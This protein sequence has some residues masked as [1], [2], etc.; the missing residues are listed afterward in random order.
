MELIAFRG[1]Q[2]G[3]E[4]DGNTQVSD[5]G[6]QAVKSSLIGYVTGQNCVTGIRVGKLK[7][8]KPCRPFTVYIALYLDPIPVSHQ[9]PRF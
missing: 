9:I 4:Q 6:K 8:T 1:V 3:D 7:I 5:L 2:A